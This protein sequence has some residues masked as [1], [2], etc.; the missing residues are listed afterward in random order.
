MKRR[1]LITGASGGIGRAIA[2]SL[3]PTSHLYLAGRN[4]EALQ[5]LADELPSAEVLI[6]DLATE[7]GIATIASGVRS[8]D[9]LVHSAGVLHLG[10]VEELSLDQ[11]RESLELNLLA[12]VAL[13]RAL[14]PLLRRSA[15]HVVMVNSGLGHHSAAGSGAYSA[16]KF[17]MRAFADALRLEEATHGVRVTSVHPGRVDTPMQAQMHSWEQKD[18]DGAAWIQPA[19]VASVVLA[20]LDLGSNAV[21]DSIN[22]NPTHPARP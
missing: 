21:I 12:P 11:W 10:T 7:A 17:G 16:S 2:E 9:V 13:T 5:N 4:R 6:G 15:A 8:L 19:Q 22:I 1:V 20:A 18:Y 3:A 14:L